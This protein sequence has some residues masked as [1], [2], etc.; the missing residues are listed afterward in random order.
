MFRVLRIDFLEV[1]KVHEHVTFGS[2]RI[3][4]RLYIFKRVGFYGSVF[5]VSVGLR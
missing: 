1:K 2:D 4:V 5:A 3:T